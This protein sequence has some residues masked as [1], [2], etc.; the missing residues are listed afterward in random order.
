MFPKN[1]SDHLKNVSDVKRGE[2]TSADK[3]EKRKILVFSVGAPSNDFGSDHNLH[4]DAT[5]KPN[6]RFGF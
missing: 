6:T 4:L 5:K 3:T 1:V 2:G